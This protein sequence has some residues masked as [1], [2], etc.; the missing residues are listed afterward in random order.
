MS[1][2]NKNN[3]KTTKAH[4]TA[5]K[6]E[7]SGLFSRYNN[8]IRPLKKAVKV[9]NAAEAAYETKDSLR[10]ERKLSEAG[11]AVDS[12][13]IKASDVYTDLMATYRNVLASYDYLDELSTPRMLNKL[14]KERSNFS[15]KFLF[16]L[17]RANAG[18]GDFVPKESGARPSYN[19][20]KSKFRFGNDDSAAYRQVEAPVY[21]PTKTSSF[22]PEEN[23]SYPSAPAPTYRGAENT[24]FPRVEQVQRG[25][26]DSLPGEKTRS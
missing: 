16:L 24:V 7:L 3:Y 14:D 23:L 2:E 18:L 19:A 17:D 20:A 4:I 11:L 10:N 6:K 15:D 1:V 9:Y 8:A 12:P 13:L 22:R 21:T 5:K 25:R 26:K